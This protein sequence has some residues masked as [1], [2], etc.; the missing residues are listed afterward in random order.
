MRLLMAG[1]VPEII[2]WQALISIKSKLKK[3]RKE[4]YNTRRPLTR[5]RRA[6]SCSNMD[7]RRIPISRP[8]KGKF[9]QNYKL[10]PTIGKGGFS[11]VYSAFKLN[12]RIY[13]LVNLKLIN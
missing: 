13:S 1:M 5:L 3:K 8:L 9:K 7:E 2:L 6:L 12:T 10:G 4:G 11:K